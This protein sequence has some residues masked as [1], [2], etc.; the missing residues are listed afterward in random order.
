MKV[1]G[2]Y[3][4]L[5]SLDAREHRAYDT[6]F[7]PTMILVLML[8]CLL[9]FVFNGIACVES[10]TSVVCCFICIFIKEYELPKNFDVC[11][12]AEKIALLDNYTG[13]PYL[14]DKVR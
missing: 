10:E 8:W 7:F 5:L 11:R 3:A 9:C 1:I 4:Q 13:H 6:W 14:Y 2:A 12:N